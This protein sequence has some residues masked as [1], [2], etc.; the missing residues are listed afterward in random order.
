MCLDEMG[1][2]ILVIGQRLVRSPGFDEICGIVDGH[3]ETG[4][5]KQA[6]VIVI[7]AE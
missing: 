5:F 7:V 2:T 6:D 3:G 4:C 1:N